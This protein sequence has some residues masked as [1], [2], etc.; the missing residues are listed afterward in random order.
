[1][2]IWHQFWCTHT[3]TQHNTTFH[4]YSNDNLTEGTAQTTSPP[5]PP[6]HL[7]LSPNAPDLKW[8]E[9]PTIVLL[10]SRMFLPWSLAVVHI[11]P[12]F[13]YC[14]MSQQQMQ[15]PTP[16]VFTGNTRNY[17]ILMSVMYHL[18]FA[19]TLSTEGNLY[20]IRSASIV[21]QWRELHLPCAGSDSYKCDYLSCVGSSNIT[22]NSFLNGTDFRVK[23]K[24]LYWQLG[25]GYYNRYNV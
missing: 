15:L 5:L 16:T 19:P 1:M 14:W 3:S 2:N 13:H 25:R 4:S 9:A 23:Q 11:T 18:Q 22:R 17:A 8:P 7:A 24:S 20:K 12:N 6:S 21:Q 10:G